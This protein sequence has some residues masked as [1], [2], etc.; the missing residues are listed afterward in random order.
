MARAVVA[1]PTFDLQFVLVRSA[2]AFAAALIVSCSAPVTDATPSA[3]TPSLPAATFPA[4]QRPASTVPPPGPVSAGALPDAGIVFFSDYGGTV[5]PA[6]YRYDGA[7]G[8]LTQIAWPGSI[9]GGVAHETASGVYLQGPNGRWDLLHWDGSR[10]S[11]QEFTACQQEPGFFAS[12]CSA[13]ATGVGVGY[14]SHTGPGPG[15][16]TGPWCPPAFIRLPGTTRSTSF[17][18]ELCVQWAQVSA[19]GTQLLIGDLAREASPGVRVEDRCAPGYVTVDGI[20]CYQQRLW[21]M[22]V[23]GAP[24]QLRLSPVLPGFFP[25]NLSPDG[26]SA[27]GVHLGALVLVDLPT[28]KSSSLGPVGKTLSLRWSPS[29]ALA[30]VGGSAEDSWVDKSVV[31]IAA[32]GST[33]S[34]R[35]ATALPIGLAPA[36][37]PAG[38]RLAW[39]ASPAVVPGADVAAQDYLAGKGAGDRRVLVSDLSAD[40]IEIRCGDRVAEGVRW[41]HD[42][43][44]LLLLCRR[45]GATVNAVE[46]WLYR[47]GAAGGSLAPLVRGITWGAIDPHGVA[48]DLFAN[49][50]WSRAAATR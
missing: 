45:P 40:P 42:G 7:S 9:L 11:D 27:T 48:P 14:G 38:R 43:T 36:W 3:A 6:A 18:P 30:F 33:R 34:V 31:V 21:T 15:P 19:D 16:F 22:P 47:I 26:R 23:G 24:R 29:G 1:A 41:S 25:T 17:P 12:W 44:A 35:G 28:G 46:L 2:L 5:T 8:A 39:I 32:D 50:A 13:S 20:S 49:T 10:A 4:S 37:D